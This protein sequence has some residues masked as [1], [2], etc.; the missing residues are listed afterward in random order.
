MNPEWCAECKGLKTAEE[1]AEQ[2][3]QDFKANIQGWG[4]K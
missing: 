2:E 1:E 4:K 3:D